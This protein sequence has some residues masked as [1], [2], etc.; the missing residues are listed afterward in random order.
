MEWFFDTMKD[1]T[2]HIYHLLW[3]G[4]ASWTLPQSTVGLLPGSILSGAAAV[5]V[6]LLES[7]TRGMHHKTKDAK[8]WS[9][10]QTEKPSIFCS[11]S[12]LL[13][14]QIII[15]KSVPDSLITYLFLCQI[16]SNHTIPESI[17]MYNEI[18]GWSKPHQT[19][20]YQLQVTGFE[21]CKVHWT[22]KR[23]KRPSRVLFPKN[24]VTL[25]SAT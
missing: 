3:I 10:Q 5:D 7:N 11:G 15:S 6:H 25:I 9:L 22:P 4:L 17:M 1:H 8:E 24:C 23:T 21:R 18:F 19:P 16:P 2:V 20:I 13:K 12:F 14:V